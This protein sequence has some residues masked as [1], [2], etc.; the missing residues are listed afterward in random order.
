MH[1]PLF[2]YKKGDDSQLDALMRK[3]AEEAALSPETIIIELP[4]PLVLVKHSVEGSLEPYHTFELWYV[5]EGEDFEA[6]LDACVASELLLTFEGDFEKA[7]Q[8]CRDYLDE[9][10][11]KCPT[12]WVEKKAV[13]EAVEKD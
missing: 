12:L 7:R 9:N 5:P 1:A 8:E 11:L 13:V 2:G 3:A 4:K 10:Y 6:L